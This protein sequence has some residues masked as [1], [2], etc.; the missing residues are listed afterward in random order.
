MRRVGKFGGAGP[1]VRA[2]GIVSAV[3]LTVTG[4]TFA[5]LQ[6]QQAVLTGNTIQSATADLRIGTSSSS[7]AASRAGF[8]F[9]DLVPGGPAMPADGNT[10]YLKNYGSAPLALKLTVGSVPT[11]TS[12]VDLA[13]VFVQ[14][15]RVD[16]NVTQTASLQSLIDGY[17]ANGLAITDVL[18][19]GATGTFR[20]RASMAADAFS[21]TNATIGAIDLVFSGTAQ[22]ASTQS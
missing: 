6:S 14:L 18:S 4:V 3:G 22:T 7:F 10:F 19:G 15:T 16:S 21:G 8:S 17:P 20:V 13:K 11:N 2:A 5:A 9:Q 12:N 1:L